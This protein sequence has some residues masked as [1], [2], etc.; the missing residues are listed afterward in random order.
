[1]YYLYHFNKKI[2]D[3]GDKSVSIDIPDFLVNAI[4]CSRRKLMEIISQKSIAIE[5]NPTSNLKIS[6]IETYNEHPILNFYHKNI[7]GDS[8]FPYMNVSINTDDKS[9]FSTSL[10][11]EYTYLLFYL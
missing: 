6:T 10:R 4:V 2:K 8:S 11:N 9:V 5:S 3:K 1:M 7:K